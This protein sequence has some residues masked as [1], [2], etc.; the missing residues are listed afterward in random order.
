MTDILLVQPPIRDFYLTSKRTI[1]Y[2]LA[3]IA[4]TLLK[5]GFSV[6]ILDC[7]ATAKSRTI[8]LPREMAYLKEYYGRLDISP[9]ALFH[10][11]K[12]FG[13]SYQDI[14]RLAGKSQAWLVGISSLFS[15]YSSEAVETAKSIRRAL[16]HCKI[17]LGGHHPTENPE[18]I[19]RH[20]A[21]DYCIRGEGEQALV[22][23][24]GAL[25]TGGKIESVSG[26]VF[27]EPDE[28]IRTNSP[29]LIEKL[30]SLPPP[31]FDLIE[32]GFYQRKS[33]GSAVVC[34]SRGCPLRCS[35]CSLGAAS[36]SHYRRRSVESVLQEIDLAVTEYNA[37]FIDFEDEN[38]SMEKTW[39]VELLKGIRERFGRQNLELR[40]MNGLFPPTLD[41]EVIEAMAAA[42]FKTL[43]LSLGTTSPHQLKRFLRPDVTEAFDRALSSI[44]KYD[45]HA[46][47]Y[48][49][50]GA[51][52]Q[53]P[54]ESLQ[55][56]MFLAEKR[57]LAGVSVFYP[58]PGSRD[59]RKCE[60]KGILPSSFD[61]MRATALPISSTTTRD[62]SITLLRLGRLLN[63]MKSLVDEGREV[64]EP[65]HIEAT[66]RMELHDKR[67]IG[68]ILLQSF[69][70]DGILRG[71]AP[72]GELFEHKVN[73]VLCRKFL[74]CLARVKLRGTRI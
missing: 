69:L 28:T 59:F 35:Y 43:N 46:V 5:E 63:F 74:D 12:H 16:P 25:R 14:E 26:I 39:F 42:G 47:A 1:P 57:V 17:V 53:D 4:A 20:E 9:F 55:D 61:L 22:E 15:A 64:L 70:Q 19:M 36:Y 2:G 38:I 72:G 49:I 32:H 21:I 45:L 23:L 24:A 7:L 58:S 33:R 50:V 18:A 29:I 3:N 60:R 48:I 68:K 73:K 34:A 13:H 8:P 31:A 65:S 41:D 71:V 67:K 30:D 27:R 56:L 52:E 10:Q 37:G 6:R 40:A 51:P 11:Y 62:D 54:Y 66:P 44:E